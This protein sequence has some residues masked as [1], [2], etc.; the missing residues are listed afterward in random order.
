MHKWCCRTG[1]MF[2]RNLCYTNLMRSLV[3]FLLKLLFVTI[4]SFV[5]LLYLLL[6]SVVWSCY[7]CCYCQLCKATIFIAIAI[8]MKLP[9]LLLLPDVWSYHICCC[10]QLCEAAIFVTIV[11]FVKLLY[12]L[13]LPFVWSYHICCPVSCVELPYSTKYFLLYWLL[14]IFKTFWYC[15]SRAIKLPFS[16]ERHVAKLTLSNIF[17]W[18]YWPCKFQSSALLHQVPKNLHIDHKTLIF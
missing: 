6:L 5:K 8:C 9:Y 15:V 13:L 17:T 10:C 2:L 12:L 3:T 18:I 4:V 16:K 14:F 11:S 7:I 1:C